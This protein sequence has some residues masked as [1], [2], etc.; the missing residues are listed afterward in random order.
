MVDA[1]VVVTL[2]IDPGEAGDA[3]AEHLR[4]TVAYG[5]TL[6]PFE[7]ANV[8]RRR[9]NGGLLSDAEASLAHARLL[10]LP[11]EL[12]PWE[13][14]ARRAWA[15]GANLTSYDAAYVALAEELDAVLLTRDTRLAA[16]PGV[17]CEI[18]V[19]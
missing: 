6:L 17:A 8:L 5:P 19:V 14:V 1:S 4:D 3:I 10:D 15:L 13:P 16:A 9:R 11:I 7:V 18:V 12:W 2:L